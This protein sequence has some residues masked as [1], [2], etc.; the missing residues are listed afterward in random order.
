MAYDAKIKSASSGNKT[1]RIIQPEEPVPAEI[2]AE[3]IMKVADGF[4]KIQ[5]S[6][7]SDRALIALLKDATGLG[8]GEIK[9]VLAG[10]E[11]LKAFYL[12]DWKKAA[13]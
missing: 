5:K 10:L 13:K 8:R 6:G 3:S 2:L 1:P 11:S 12:R 9:A 7:L 4:E